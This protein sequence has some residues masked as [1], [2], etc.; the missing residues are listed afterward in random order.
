[1]WLVEHGDADLPVR[2]GPFRVMLGAP[3]CQR[4]LCDL[5]D[6]DIGPD[7]RYK[8]RLQ[9]EADLAIQHLL[10]EVPVEIN[11]DGEVAEVHVS[12]GAVDD[13]IEVHVKQPYAPLQCNHRVS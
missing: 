6:G 3:L 13:E 2:V 4:Q 9:R 12:V 7:R 10:E 11:V 1:M 5:E 8:S